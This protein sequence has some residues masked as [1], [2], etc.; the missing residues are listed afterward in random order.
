MTKCKRVAIPVGVVAC[1]ALVG[2][3]THPALTVL[4]LTVLTVAIGYGV[5]GRHKRAGSAALVARWTKRATKHHGVANF[6]TILRLSSW[7]TLRR[8]AT[9]LRPSL[10]GQ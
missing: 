8:H 7:W 5:L 2:W 3:F 6:W 4:T 9:V 1:V 10:N